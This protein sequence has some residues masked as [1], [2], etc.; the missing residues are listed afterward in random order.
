[1]WVVPHSSCITWDLN[2]TA[3]S[4]APPQVLWT[5]K[6][7]CSIQ[8][9]VF[10]QALPMTGRHTLAQQPLWALWSSVLSFLCSSHLCM[11]RAIAVTCKPNIQYW[12]PLIP[13]NSYLKRYFVIAFPS[14]RIS[15]FCNSQNHVVI[16]NHRNLLSSS[17]FLEEENESQDQWLTRAPWLSENRDYTRILLDPK[18]QQFLGGSADHYKI[19][20]DPQ[21]HSKT[22]IS[23]LNT[24]WGEAEG[25]SIYSIS[26]QGPGKFNR[27]SKPESW[28]FRDTHFLSYH[29]EKQLNKG[30]GPS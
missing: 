10:L 20:Q 5:R 4:W 19:R 26:C 21:T 8:K 6:P 22:E 2:R 15:Y 3:H 7:G 17:H 18:L 13:T 16:M 1:M 29:E 30:A 11:L 23:R 25:K 14:W 12:I 28:L 27:L 24:N 9:S